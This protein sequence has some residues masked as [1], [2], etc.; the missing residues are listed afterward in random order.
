[1]K[2]SVLSFRAAVLMVI[3]GMIWGIAMGISQDHS[4]LPAH[5]HLNLLGWVSLFLFGIYNHLH[6]AVDL[7]RLATVQVW[8]WIAGTIILTIGVGLVHS[9]HEIGDPIA[10]VSSLI[11]LADTLLFGWLVFR[12]EPSGLISQRSTVPAE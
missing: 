9:G 3:A 2:A 10:A 1:M 8:V 12:L 7:N 11:E 4:T 6:P 5:A